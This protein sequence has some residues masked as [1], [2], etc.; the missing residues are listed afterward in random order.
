MMEKSSC[1]SPILTAYESYD[2]KIFCQ[3]N[4]GHCLDL[5]FE[6]IHG[7]FDDVASPDHVTFHEIW[8][9]H[10]YLFFS[11]QVILRIHCLR[12]I[13]DVIFHSA[14]IC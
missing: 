8:K 7:S 12:P 9:D 6:W 2:G 11:S 13:I 1:Y 4:D 10:E 14:G 5:M 3:S